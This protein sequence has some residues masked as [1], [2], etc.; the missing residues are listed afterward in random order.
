MRCL[1]IGSTGY[2]GARLVPR[3]LAAGHEVRCLVRDPHTVRSL[4]WAREVG[5][6]HGD[7][8]DVDAVTAAL[9]DMDVIY[10]LVHSLHHADF[11][12]RDAA[13]ARVV[14]AAAAR[15]SVRRIVYLGGLQPRGP[16]VTSRHLSSRAAVAEIF[17]ACGV[18]TAALQAA[19]IMGSGSTSFEILRHLTDR[20]PVMVIPNWVRHRTQP[21][22]VRDVLHYLVGCAELP[23]E[24]NRRFDIGGPDVLTY[25]DM[26]HGYA[27]VAGLRRRVVLSVPF[28]SPTLS[29]SFVDLVTPVPGVVA[30][31]LIESLVH[32]LMCTDDDIE[33]QVPGPPHGRLGY[34]DSVVEALRSAPPAPSSDDAPREPAQP[35][36]T[37][38]PGFGPADLVSEHTLT[39]RASPSA[40]WRIVEGI[41]GRHGWYTVPLVWRARGW[42]D[43]ALGGVGADRGRRDPDRV[44]IG[45]VVDG[46]RVERR[47]CGH[48]LRLRAEMTMPGQAWL[49]ITVS[50]DGDS[51]SAYR[52]RVTFRPRGLA[53]HLYWWSQRPAHDFVFAVMARTVLLAAEDDERCAR[54]E[55]GHPT[56]SCRRPAAPRA[57]PAAPRSGWPG[58][59]AR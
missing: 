48:W 44:R 56:I 15:G 54:G 37:D 18:P 49:D 51:G 20:L 45:D 4:P 35:W 36:P 57:G 19:A 59:R 27:R 17:L 55:F 2:V 10:Y 26:I 34:E 31:P 24:V 9:R 8:L 38:P 47:E 7:A 46:W 52:Q 1:V 33:S 53:G 29:A 14:A 22:A 23:A 39:T 30:K 16:G 42:V 58:R 12:A 25:L 32:E 13:A 6:V 11:V 40:V 21:I 43:R 41:G 3:L 28:A 50:D 5:V